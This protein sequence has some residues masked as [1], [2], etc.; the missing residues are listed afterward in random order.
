MQTNNEWEELSRRWREE[1]AK[2]YVCRWSKAPDIGKV[3]LSM[4]AGFDDSYLGIR[5]AREERASALY[6]GERIGTY[7]GRDI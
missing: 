7:K 5:R 3:D 4:I 1:C 2:P 6:D